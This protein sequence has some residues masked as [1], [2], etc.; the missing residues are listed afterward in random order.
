MK[1]LLLFLVIILI[2]PVVCAQP[3]NVTKP[4]AVSEPD[5]NLHGSGIES[6]EPYILFDVTNSDPN[7]K[8]E[9]YVS[10]PIPND[11]GLDEVIGAEYVNG[12]ITT[13]R[14]VLDTAPHSKSVDFKIERL[15]TD[16]VWL[17]C[18]LNYA[19]FKEGKGY[20]CNVIL[21]EGINYAYKYCPAPTYLQKEE[22]IRLGPLPPP[23]LS[24][25]ED[26]FC[27]IKKWFSDL[28]HGEYFVLK[29]LLVILLLLLMRELR[30]YIL[31]T[32]GFRYFRIK[33]NSMPKWILD[34]FK[35]EIEKHHPITLRTKIFHYKDN[36]FHYVITRDCLRIC[37]YYQGTGIRVD[38]Q[39]SLVSRIKNFLIWW[40]T[41]SAGVWLVTKIIP[42]VSIPYKFVILLLVGIIIETMSRIMQ[43]FKDHRSFG[44]NKG[45]RLFIIWSL[46]HAISYFGLLYILDKFLITNIP[47]KIV[48]IGLGITVFSRIIWRLNID[49][50]RET[51]NIALVILLIILLYLT[52]ELPGFMIFIKKALV[53]I[54]QFFISRK[55]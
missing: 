31:E 39:G 25:G 35:Q 22:S 54:K 51:W 46:I 30:K 2:L 28:I 42:F 44:K 6:L 11:M 38:L 18:S 29:L 17:N 7:H 14:F 24:C 48:F 10:C 50:R 37:R 36:K 20:V 43:V 15:N 1:K 52:K 26:I 21:R 13:N 27:K 16:L 5:I 8:L 9:G 19:L 47:L 33:K 12:I 41:F 49:S 3:G 40:L 32:R 34:K 55:V 45:P 23:T 4:F 53:S